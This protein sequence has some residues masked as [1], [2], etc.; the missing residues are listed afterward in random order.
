MSGRMFRPTVVR[1]PKQAR[2]IWLSIYNEDGTL[3]DCKP[4]K[5][6]EKDYTLKESISEILRRVKGTN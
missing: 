3:K 6:T 4:H 2:E 5:F 1:C